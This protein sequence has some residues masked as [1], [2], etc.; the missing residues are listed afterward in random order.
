[1]YTKYKATETG[2]FSSLKHSTSKYQNVYH[3]SA[4][5]LAGKG[6]DD[7]VL[8][9]RPISSYTSGLLR[10]NIYFGPKTGYRKTNTSTEKIEGSET[11][12]FTIT[13]SV[14]EATYDS[15]T[16]TYTEGEATVTT[17]TST[18]TEEWLDAP[19]ETYAYYGSAIDD[20]L[21]LEF[22]YINL[23]ELGANI[24]LY[25]YSDALLTSDGSFSKDLIIKNALNSNFTYTDDA[26]EPQQLNYKFPEN[27]W[28]HVTFEIY[29]KTGKT[30]ADI[31]VYVDGE[32]K[33]TWDKA[34]T[35]GPSFYACRL[36]IKPQ[37]Y[38]ETNYYEGTET[39]VKIEDYIFALDNIKISA[40]E[41]ADEYI[42]ASIGTNEAE[43]I[44]INGD[45]ILLTNGMTTEEL[46]N[47]TNTTLRAYKSYDVMTTLQHATSKTNAAKLSDLKISDSEPLV[48]G[49]ILVA[50]NQAKNG[51]AY[52]T[53]EVAD[54]LVAK[55]DGVVLSKNGS[56]ALDKD[57]VVNHTET[58]A[59]AVDRMLIAGVY[60]E[61]G[62]LID[63]KINEPEE[64]LAGAVQDMIYVTIP[65]ESLAGLGANSKIKA[66]VWVDSENIQPADVDEQ[67]LTLIYS[68]N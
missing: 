6:I 13:K 21:T 50:E 61:T 15:A 24:T 16:G 33:G 35:R 65:K 55:Q 60:N 52:Y 29:T 47:A 66:F 28:T 1:M 46:M 56:F 12:E 4:F 34:S 39:A 37:F 11:G 5:G 58:P 23:G 18:D 7:Q 48:T 38:K 53:V 62:K 19:E 40:G 27:K 17:S 31:K 42:P 10:G 51:Y 64:G 54:G 8:Y 22:D 20:V 63:V 68:G 59:S 57:I 25:C 3:P 14:V 67:S 2:S 26:G 36:E 9:F 49:D 43:G 44:T 32:Y 30:N 41:N 45:K